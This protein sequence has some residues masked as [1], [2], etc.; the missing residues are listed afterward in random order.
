VLAMPTSLKFVSFRLA[1]SVAAM[2]L[3]S[4]SR[5]P[6]QRPKADFVSSFVLIAQTDTSYYFA[7]LGKIRPTGNA[8]LLLVRLYVDPRPGDYFEDS[9]AI[10]RIGQIEEGW[11]VDCK[12][13]TLMRY[14]RALYDRFHKRVSYSVD[15]ASPPR[16]YPIGTVAAKLVVV[17]CSHRSRSN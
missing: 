9:L 3:Y 11:L 12:R 17:T 4:A 10:A 13:N 14:D 7:D 8:K 6:G 1:S 2:L 5:L 15:S 16:R